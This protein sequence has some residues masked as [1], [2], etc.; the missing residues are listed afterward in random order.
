M[1]M[2]ITWIISGGKTDV[3]DVQQIV[4]NDERVS[5]TIFKPYKLH[6]IEND[7]KASQIYDKASE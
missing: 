3:Y 2:M 4:R 6:V 1:N 7:S 5:L